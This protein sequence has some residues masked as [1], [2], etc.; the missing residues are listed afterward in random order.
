MSYYQAPTIIHVQ[1]PTQAKTNN[2]DLIQ[3][4]ALCTIAGAVLAWGLYKFF[5]V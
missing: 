3:T 1:K 2:L 4:Y 5:A